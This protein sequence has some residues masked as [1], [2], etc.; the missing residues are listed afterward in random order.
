LVYRQ[1]RAEKNRQPC[2][3][4]GG[5]MD[6]IRD[7]DPIETQEWID[8]IEGVIE[9][10]GSE[11]AHFLLDRILHAGRKRGA[12]LPVASITPY[13]RIAYAT[14]GLLGGETRFV[15]A[16]SGHVAGVINPPSR[17]KRSYWTNERGSPTYDWFDNLRQWW[18]VHG[19][20]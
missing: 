8:A 3:Y 19:V 4:A 9:V 13:L 20:M 12:V 17:N 1:K 15:L 11:R 7:V 18:S 6:D 16:A 2:S 14:T 5:I 10:E